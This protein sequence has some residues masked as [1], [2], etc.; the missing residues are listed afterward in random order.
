MTK[1]NNVVVGTVGTMPLTAPKGL[2][3]GNKRARLNG[4]NGQF[5]G[6]KR[7]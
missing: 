6:N 5:H 7:L 4:K 1:L 2:I 3:I